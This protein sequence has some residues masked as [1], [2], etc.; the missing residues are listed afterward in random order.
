MMSEA[1]KEL[2]DADIILVV[3]TSL[4]V[5]PAAGILTYAPGEMRKIIVDKKIPDVSGVKN[6]EVY[7]MKASEGVKLVV[8]KLLK[9]TK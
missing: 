2:I 8:E 1:L 5:Y 6:I 3:G 7:E 4:Q 9:E